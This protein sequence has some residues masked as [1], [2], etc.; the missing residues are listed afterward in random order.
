MGGLKLNCN[1]T[2][3]LDER[4][5]T[6]SCVLRNHFGA[7][8]FAFAANIGFGCVTCRVMGNIYWDWD[9]NFLVES[10]SQLAIN[11]LRHVYASYH[12]CLA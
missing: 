2:I 12:T 1:A 9:K 8:I 7:V 6:A 4:K 11:L 10:D 5:V 3:S